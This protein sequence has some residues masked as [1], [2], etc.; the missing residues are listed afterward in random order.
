MGVDVCVVVAVAVVVVVGVG[1]KGCICVE[2]FTGYLG[3]QK[4][5]SK[6]TIVAHLVSD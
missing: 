5:R 3:R 6:L 4:C 2:L 1:V